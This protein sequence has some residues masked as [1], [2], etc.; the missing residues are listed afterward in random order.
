M[1][2]TL[3]GVDLLIQLLPFLLLRLNLRL[4]TFSYIY[5]RHRLRHGRG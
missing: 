1:D 5:I 3:V 4:Q 2:P